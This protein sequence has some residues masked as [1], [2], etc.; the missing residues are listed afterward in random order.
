MKVRTHTYETKAFKAVVLE[1][2]GR[3]VHAP[4]VIANF[5]GRGLLELEKWLSASW[6]I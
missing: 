4:K 5:K 3:I 2:N 6:S 1:Q